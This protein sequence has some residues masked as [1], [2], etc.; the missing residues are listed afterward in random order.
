MPGGGDLG[1]RMQNQS[2]LISGIGIA[3]A[4]LA[5]WL[6]EQ[7]FKPTLVERASC[8]RTSG[9][10]ID[11]WGLGYDIAERMGILSDLKFE[12]YDVEEVRFVNTKGRRVAGFSPDIFRSLTA[13]R[14]V[15]LA[16]GDLAKLI[17]NKIEGRYE[18]MFGDSIADV[19]EN[20][21]GVDVVFERGAGRRFDLVVGADGLHSAVRELV[22]GSQNRFEKYLGYHVAAFEI[23]GYRPR[24]EGVYVSCAV[25]SK[26]VSR[27]AM[28]D[29]RTLFLFVFA[30]GS[31]PQIV[32]RGAIAHKAVL[33]NEFG[34]AGWECPKVLAALDTIDD[35]Y[36]DRVSQIQMDGWSRGRVALVGDAAFCPSLL[37]GQGAALAMISAYVLAG[38]LN[39]SKGQF[40]DAFSR[41][42]RLLRPF[43]TAKQGAARQFAHSFAPKTRWGLFLRSQITKAIALPFVANRAFGGLLDRIELPNYSNQHQKG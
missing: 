42:E 43:M 23:E 2:V 24:D 34:N 20:S 40:E 1:S 17:Y 15:S 22:F 7:G 5:Y 26:Q 6:G 9:Y 31:R 12:G 33:R 29:N 16:R 8:P 30:I 25:P 19:E 21:A 11:F 4:T 41:Y 39:R 14:Y 27:F 32:E 18:T 13:G 35:I 28:R 3:G 36:F 37:A 10:V 38:E